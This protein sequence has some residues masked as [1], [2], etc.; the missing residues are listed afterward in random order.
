MSYSNQVPSG[1]QI[2]SKL[3]IATAF[4]ISYVEAKGQRIDSGS[5]DVVMLLEDEDF[6]NDALDQVSSP[7]YGG[8]SQRSKTRTTAE[9]IRNIL[10]VLI[11]LILIGACIGGIAYFIYREYKKRKAQEEAEAS[12]WNIFKRS[13]TK[14]K[15]DNSSFSFNMFADEETASKSSARGNANSNQS[16]TKPTND[17]RLINQ[18]S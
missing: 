14:H 18:Q 8:T 17:S 3:A 7:F 4:L 2:A 11:I 15:S 13:K 1:I 10:A 6:Y 12:S 5:S 9:S 16:N